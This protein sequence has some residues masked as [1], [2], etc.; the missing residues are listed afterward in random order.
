M[1]HIVESIN[2]ILTFCSSLS[3]VKERILMETVLSW[4]QSRWSG[5]TGAGEW[6]ALTGSSTITVESTYENQSA[7][8][9]FPI[10]PRSL[11]LWGKSVKHDIRLGHS[12]DPN[13]AF[14]ASGMVRF[15]LSLVLVLGYI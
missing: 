7:S 14:P 13:I 11:E 5:F 1:V 8:A 15:S 4:P 12:V 6:S 10:T 9:Q 3:P 2:S